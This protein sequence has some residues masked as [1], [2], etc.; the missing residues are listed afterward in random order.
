MSSASFF[1]CQASSFKFQY[2]FNNFCR[3]FICCL[4]NE[5][6]VSKL[7]DYMRFINSQIITMT[8]APVTGQKNDDVSASNYFL[9]KAHESLVLCCS[10][11]RSL[12]GRGRSLS[13]VRD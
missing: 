7:T 12:L 4:A 13:G 2:S 1:I 6:L 11:F 5:I 3:L 9:V 8:E 10:Y